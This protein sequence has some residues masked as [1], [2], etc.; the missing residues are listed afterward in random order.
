MSQ[1]SLSVKNTIA[2]PSLPLWIGMA[3]GIFFLLAMVDS[4]IATPLREI[5]SLI[6][7]FFL[8]LCSFPVTR[9]G[10]ILSTPELTFDVVPAC[11][12]SVTLR[13]MVG[14]GIY[15]CGTHPRLNLSRKIIGSCLTVP[16]ALVANGIRV[17]ILV[18]LSYM[19]G[20][21]ITEGLLHSLIGIIGFILAMVGF[22][23]ITE[24]LAFAR[25][26][27]PHSQNNI[28][29]WFF[30]ILILGFIYFPFLWKYLDY[31]N[32]AKSY[33]K[34]D[35]MG[36]FLIIAAIGAGV[37]QF[38]RVPND[39]RFVR[40]P[41]GIFFLSMVMVFVSLRVDVTYFLGLSLLLAI[42]AVICA[43]KGKAFT[44]SAIPLLII[45]YLGF[46]H[47]AVQ[48]NWLT[49]R[50]FSITTLTSSMLIRIPAAVLLFLMFLKLR[51]RIPSR[52]ATEG[53]PKRFIH[54]SIAMAMIML[55]FQGHTYSVAN[56]NNLNTRLVFSYIQGDW[57]GH[58]LPIS[59]LS[60]DF[61]GKKNIWSRQYAKDNH[62]IRVLIN[63]SGGNRHRNHPPEYCLTGGG[64]KV[65]KRSKSVRQIG[66]DKKI[67]VTGIELVKGGERKTM[68]YWLG[69][70]QSEYP[71][72]TSM[73]IEDTR[74]RLTGQRTN[75]F[76]FRVFSSTGNE[77]LN[78]F[79]KIFRFSF[80]EP[81][82]AEL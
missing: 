30:L 53:N 22:Y 31:Y 15:W 28:L 64:W 46:P 47:I 27:T 34:Y 43:T 79:L 39:A 71:D 67:Y 50:L 82:K 20:S 65:D 24:L 3:G 11:S 37:I 78:D 21:V 45:I 7:H 23:L 51:P 62:H 73:T 55:A 40:M 12:G 6:S 10:T 33:G 75:W 59:D 35:R 77:I 9:Q 19:L 26:Q 52:V 17:A 60:L 38:L 66:P 29:P 16:I 57:I 25:P 61:F 76:L 4:F 49:T 58:D 18:G 54:L 63:A 42:L 5:S 80:E 32:P 13:V 44:V 14:F 2:K 36:I 68:V 1:A 8:Q 81:E 69:D 70:G 72:Y 56:K 74:R 48:V 41:L